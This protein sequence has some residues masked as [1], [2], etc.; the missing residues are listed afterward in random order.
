MADET[1]SPE[2]QPER[3]PV[4]KL[5]DAIQNLPEDQREELFQYFRQVIHV[6]QTT[7]LMPPP[8]ML[9]A[10]TPEIQRIIVDE[11]AQHGQHRRTSEVKVIDA[12]IQRERRGMWLGFALAMTLILCGTAVIL[13]G[14]R[15]EGLGVIGSTAV[16][17]A[18]V[19]IVDRRSRED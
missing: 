8:S 5:P 11:F 9:A 17:L 12:S 2:T 7:G 4:P 15:A 6:E 19:Y 3:S 18:A 14:F 13:A 10:Y 1:V 16:V